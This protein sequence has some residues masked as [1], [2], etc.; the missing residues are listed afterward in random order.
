MPLRQSSPPVLDACRRHGAT[1]P[2]G[3]H[4]L[5][6]WTRRGVTCVRGPRCRV[7]TERSPGT[8]YGHGGAD[9]HALVP[10]RSPIRGRPT[11]TAA[12]CQHTLCFITIIVSRQRLTNTTIVVDARPPNGETDEAADDRTAVR[13]NAN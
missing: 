8:N 2:H 11:P 13:Q 5:G 1:R 6:L 10:K 9:D 4:A 7:S 12:N 3:P